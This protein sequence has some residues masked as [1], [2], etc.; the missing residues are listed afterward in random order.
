MN[1]RLLF[2]YVAASAAA[3]VAASGVH[4]RA[5]GEP[6][7]IG[8]G[9]IGVGHSHAAGKMEAIRSLA[10]TFEVVGVA[11]SDAALRAAAERNPAYAGLPWL[12]EAA[13]LGN[14]DVRVVAI[15]TRMRDACAAAAHDVAVH[16]AALRAGGAWR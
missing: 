15:E 12:D 8:I 2:R 3:G 5:E 16:E 6:G 14:A 13:L 4:A 1:R 7:R 11:E 9:Q 10:D